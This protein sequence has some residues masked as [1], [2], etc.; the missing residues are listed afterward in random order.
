MKKAEEFIRKVEAFYKKY[1]SAT[2]LREAA[3]LYR[4]D[5]V[6]LLNEGK[7]LEREMAEQEGEGALERLSD[8]EKDR[9]Q[10]LVDK[11]LSQIVMAIKQSNQRLEQA[12]VVRETPEPAVQAIEPK[13]QPVKPAREEP[14]LWAPGAAARARELEEKE[15]L[16]KEKRTAL[17]RKRGPEQQVPEIQQE[18]HEE[19]P[20]PEAQVIPKGQASEG[21]AKPFVA[22]QEPQSKG[23]GFASAPKVKQHALTENEQIMRLGL[24]L[25]IK[26][27]QKYL[28]EYTLG[29][30]KEQKLRQFFGM[31]V[32]RPAYDAALER[33]KVFNQLLQ[34]LEQGMNLTTIRNG[35][36]SLPL[37]QVK[38]KAFVQLFQG[39]QAKWKDIGSEEVRESDRVK[40]GGS[41]KLT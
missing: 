35:L 37:K 29:Q 39:V 2:Y 6:T 30:K 18:V 27:N 7:K 12:S 32:G 34:G 19:I 26:A 4:L 3:D 13:H 8:I 22:Q 17:K 21:S 14:K 23:I 40:H 36:D 16:D 15:A 9:D 28:N 38:D 41:T 20:Q 31:K 1:E 10:F 5:M 11:Q 24:Q 25:L 33:N